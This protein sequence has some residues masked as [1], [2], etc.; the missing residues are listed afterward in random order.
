MIPIVCSGSKKDTDLSSTI[1]TG[2]KNGHKG[3]HIQNRNYQKIF[4]GVTGWKPISI[5]L[6]ILILKGEFLPILSCFPFILDESMIK[7]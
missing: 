2:M 4:A 3:F 7:Y 6:E 5:N 1:Q